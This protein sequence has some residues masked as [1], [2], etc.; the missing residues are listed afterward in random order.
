M[1]LFLLLMDE[2]AMLLAWYAF[3][4]KGVAVRLH[5]W[6]KVTSSEYSSGHGSCAGVISTYALMQ[7][8]YYVLGLFDYDAFEEWMIVSPVV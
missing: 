4:D 1:K 8:S 3:L 7:I 6:P 2:V 5:S